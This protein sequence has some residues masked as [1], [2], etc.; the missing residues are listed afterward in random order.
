MNVMTKRGQLDNVVTYEH[1][2]DTMA[3]LNSVSFEES[4]IGSTA[5]VLQGDSG[6][7][8]VYIANGAHEWKLLNIAGGGGSDSDTPQPDADGLL[9]YSYFEEKYAWQRPAWLPDLDSLTLPDDFDGVYLTFDNTTALKQAG[10]TIGTAANGEQFSIELGTVENGSFV[11]DSS[12]T[13]TMD[14]N[15]AS[16]TVVIDYSAFDE[17]YVVARVLPVET[18]L[19]HVCFARFTAADSRVIKGIENLC[20]ERRG[21]LPYFHSRPSGDQSGTNK[22]E[23]ITRVMLKDATPFGLEEPLTETEFS[24]LYENGYSLQYIDLS[25]F[26]TSEWTITS[27]VQTFFYCTALKYLD[28]S[29]FNTNNWQ[30]TSATNCF[31]GLYSVSTINVSTW[32]VS[33]W[34]NPKIDGMFSECYEMIQLDL[35]TWDVS[36]WGSV[37]LGYTFGSDG[38]LQVLKINN[39]DV[40]AWTSVSLASCFYQDYMLKYIPIQDWHPS[41]SLEVTN[42]YCMMEAC[43]DI[44]SFSLSNWASTKWYQ[45][46][47]SFSGFAQ[48]CWQLKS[49]D[50]SAIDISDSSWSE[51]KSTSNAAACLFRWCHQLVDLKCPQGGFDGQLNLTACYQLSHDSLMN[52]INNLRDRSETTAA[53]ITLG[54]LKFKLTLAEIAIAVDKNYTIA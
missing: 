17:D 23:W 26:D 49:C 53:T 24:H 51:K 37:N 9:P 42:C 1:M 38:R 29:Y 11:A 8:E 47:P 12:E 35:S 27:L 36:N 44:T 22:A 2:C 50:L 46:N 34:V 7:M 31:E 21:R 3:D 20:V 45:A 10:L 16:K 52:I 54:P 6:S 19:T 30:I 18:H 14:S 32:D 15:A 39:W 25:Q 48:S 4:T 5:I 41:S 40:S 28:C 33:N 13:Y 43:Q